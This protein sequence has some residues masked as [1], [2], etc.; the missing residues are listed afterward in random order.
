MNLFPI[1]SH[2]NLDPR[3]IA[4]IHSDLVQITNAGKML[5]VRPEARAS[6][7]RLIRQNA[8]NLNKL[9]LSALGDKSLKSG[10]MYNELRKN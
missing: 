6:Q 2:W 5:R 10:M 7:R 3:S 9:W 1:G 4:H 8:H